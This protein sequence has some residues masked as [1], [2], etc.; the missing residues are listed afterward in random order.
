MHQHAD[1]PHP[2]VLLRPR[3][4][5]PRGCRAAEQRNELATPQVGHGFPS[6]VGPPHDQ[7]ATN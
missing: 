2:L 3:R 5:R 4:E 7:S 1:A 6:A